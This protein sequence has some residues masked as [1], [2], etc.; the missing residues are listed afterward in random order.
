MPPDR[1][2]S[3]VLLGHE[4][5]IIHY[6]YGPTSLLPFKCCLMALAH[7]PSFEWLGS[8]QL[9]LRHRLP[10]PGR[11]LNWQCHFRMP[12]CLLHLLLSHCL[13]AGLLV[14][15]P[16]SRSPEY[17]PKFPRTPVPGPYPLSMP[18]ELQCGPRKTWL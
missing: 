18:S 12:P 15:F 1:L 11:F 3:G 10:D 16:P 14:W 6:L 7:S 13:L 8:P 4:C 17:A 2:C 9:L 5:R